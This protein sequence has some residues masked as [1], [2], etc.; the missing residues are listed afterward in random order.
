[1]FIGHFGIGFGAKKIAP[2]LSLGLLFMA[3]QFL[4]LLWPTLLLLDA[5]HVAIVP[6]ITKSTPLDFTDY[7]ISHSLLMVIGWGLLFGFIYWLIKRNAR[8][9]FILVLCVISHWVL[10]YIVHRPDLP[11][12]P[13]NSPRV[14]LGV[15][16][17]PFLSLLIEGIIF[18]TGV[19][20]YVKKTSA[21]NRIGRVGLWILVG[22]LVLIHVGNIFGPPPPDVPTIMWAGQLQWIFVLLAFWI[23]HNRE[24]VE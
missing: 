12:F 21:K 3:V 13:G 17:F 15:W 19:V 1:M 23:D 18:I 4:D 10:D 14:G 2:G 16:N 8:Y 22:L 11:L 20:I 24:A 5:E 7:P 9:A 6:G